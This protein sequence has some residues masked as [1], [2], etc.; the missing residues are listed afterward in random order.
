MSGS[1]G[2]AVPIRPDQASRI[3]QKVKQ[4]GRALQTP[5][6]Q[7]EGSDG[8]SSTLS[9][10]FRIW[11]WLRAGADLTGPGSPERTSSAHM[12]GK[13]GEDPGS[14]EHMAGYGHAQDYVSDAGQGRGCDSVAPRR[15]SMSH[16]CP[17]APGRAVPR[18]AGG[19]MG[20]GDAGR[21]RAWRRPARPDASGGRPEPAAHL[22][23]STR[24]A[25]ISRN[26][27]FP[28]MRPGAGL[29]CTAA[30]TGI[31]GNRTGPGPARAR[32]RPASAGPGQPDGDPAPARIATAMAHR[33]PPD[34]SGPLTGGSR[35]APRDAARRLSRWR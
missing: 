12:S 23:A 34:Q 35:P 25:R 13:T 3:R 33:R 4:R 14:G 6:P 32:A 1:C 10:L 2:I 22:C 28:G 31:T 15:A 20:T 21:G 27:G 7:A 24:Y 17:I 11:H 5:A 19:V 29:P 26:P 16:S 9:G 8:P 18:E 30:R